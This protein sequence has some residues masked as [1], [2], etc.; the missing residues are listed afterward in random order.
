MIVTSKTIVK[1][2][3]ILVLLSGLLWMAVLKLSMVLLEAFFLSV[4]FASYFAMIFVFGVQL[5]LFLM[6]GSKKILQFVDYS[7]GAIVVLF[8]LGVLF[9][10]ASWHL[11]IIL[12]ARA[13]RPRI[14]TLSRAMVLQGDV[15]LITG[16]VFGPEWKKGVVKVDQTNLDIISWKEEEIKVK[17]PV[18]E[19][20]GEKNLVVCKP[21]GECSDKMTVTILHPDSL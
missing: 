8:C 20:N 7:L 19:T 1:L 12:L 3:L 11:R 16:K 4:H 10:A 14:R 18:F 6:V 2:L 21:T 13:E 17:I 15:L 9:F 5:M